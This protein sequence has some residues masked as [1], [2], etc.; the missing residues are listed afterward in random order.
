[1]LAAGSEW[2]VLQNGE[3]SGCTTLSKKR[4]KYALSMTLQNQYFVNRLLK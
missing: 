3:R 1:V 4:C 2:I